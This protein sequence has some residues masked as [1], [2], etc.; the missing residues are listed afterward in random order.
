MQK[1]QPAYIGFF[2]SCQQQLFSFCTG[3]SAE[4][5]F[6]LCHLYVP[7]L[8]R[9]WILCKIAAFIYAIT[10]PA[11]FGRLFY[12]FP[13]LLQ[14]CRLFLSFLIINYVIIA[15][16]LYRENQSLPGPGADDQT[17]NKPGFLFQA[18]QFYCVWNKRLFLCQAF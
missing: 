1:N 9:R 15:S 13:P 2:S 6:L 18:D 8:P 17:K 14:K 10:S 11:A 7:I 16:F 5:V 12:F 4:F 3:L